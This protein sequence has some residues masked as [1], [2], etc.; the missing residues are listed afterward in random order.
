MSKFTAR[1]RFV[2]CSLGGRGMVM[3]RVRVETVRPGQHPSEVV[4]AVTTADGDREEL[5][6]DQR[7]LQND[8]LR[9]GYPVAGEENRLL[10]ELPRETLRGRWRIWVKPESLIR[11]A[12]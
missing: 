12:A 4:V 8:T 10:V 11:E 2:F 9:I 3:L 1:V 6:V 7:S 5:I